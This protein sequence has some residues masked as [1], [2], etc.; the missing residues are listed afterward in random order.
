MKNLLLISLMLTLTG[1]AYSSQQTKSVEEAPK[2][3]PTA[4]KVEP[5]ECHENK[6]EV[7]VCN[8]GDPSDGDFTVNPKSGG[9]NSKT[10][11]DAKNDAVGSVDG[12]D[13]NDT[14]NCAHGSNVQISGT[15]GTVNANSGS[16]GTV[17]NNGPPGS[18][19]R[20][21]IGGGHVNVP[22]GVTIPFHGG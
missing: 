9:K 6:D 22:A 8:D 7:T 1:A 16:Q 4:E 14:V 2:P 11:V 13:G 17:T 20:V 5:G 10:T 15:G 12:I 18:E 19:I 21:N 3:A